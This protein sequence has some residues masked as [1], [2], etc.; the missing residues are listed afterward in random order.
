MNVTKTLF[1]RII[2][3]INLF[4][5]TYQ[6]TAQSIPEI[7][8]DI[9]FA[10]VTV[11]LNE[12]SRVRLQR[13]VG[14]LYADRPGLQRDIES[15]RQLTPLLESLLK[16]EQ[17]PIDY[18]YAV[19]PF[20]GDEPTGYWGLTPNRANALKLVMNGVVDE[21][22]HPILA[23]ETVVAHLSRLHTVSDNYAL[24]LLRYLQD[25]T[26]ANRP[27]DKVSSTYLLLDA[28]SP[29]LIWRIMARKLAFEHEEPI[30][31]P[32]QTYLLYDYRNAAGSSLR[33]I[34]RQLQLDEE[35]FRPFNAWLKAGTIPAGK[36]YP[37]LVRVTTDE[38]LDVKSRDAIRRKSSVAGQT[39]VGFP[40]LTRLPRSTVSTHKSAVFYTI[41]DRLGVQAQPC[42][43]V[44]TLAHYG[45]IKISNLLSYNELSEKDV[46][47][48]GQIYYLERKDKRAKIP[49]HVVQKNQTLREVANV[50]G[51]RLKSLL[52]FNGIQPNQRV[53]TGRIVWLQKKRPRQQ[54][55]QYRQL[56]V[57][58]VEP[59]TE[60]SVTTAS[61]A[62][63]DSLSTQPVADS[64]QTTAGQTEPVAVL[65][66]ET[67][68]EK[69]VE[70]K[71]LPDELLDELKE[72]LKLHV[73]QPGQTYYRISQLY[74]VT[75]RQLYA[76]NNLSE[77]IPLEIGQE[78]I[79][80]L[81]RKRPPVRPKAK[82]AARPK[83]PPKPAP[84]TNVAVVSPAGRVVYHVVRAGQTVYRVALI[85]KVSVP[86]LMRLNNLT[87]YTI[88]IGQRLLIRK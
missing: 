52:Q 13:E 49:F 40:V 8:F 85:H 9:D 50:Y 33:T 69:V 2:F 65:P 22:Y 60:D 80:D 82:V 39:D 53:Q 26:L 23:T 34:S 58:E 56:P 15:L 57:N 14:Q 71:P 88:E 83:V 36:D 29:L 37:V 18:R 66:G 42:D 43:N 1:W 78:L 27:A 32:T 79:V 59:A 61:P 6:L 70:N 17:V 51:V 87:S 72:M 63:T 12:Q 16:A 28:Q 46:V 81:T 30:L 3:S 31:R 25:D 84:A 75:L 7:P 38:F 21:R 67:L 73:V 4:A 10:G 44:I 62:L 48:P 24:T 54:P 19:L 47:Q 74:G 55:V 35:R 68:P 64:V 41:N 20:A 11:H 86:Y 76:W 45:K 77:R 5:L